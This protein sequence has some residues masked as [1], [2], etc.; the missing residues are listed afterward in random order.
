MRTLKTISPGQKGTKRLLAQ[1]GAS[2][3][4]V[5]YRYDRRQRRRCKTVELIVEERPWEPPTA[6][7]KADRLA[8][9]RVAWGEASVAARIKQAGGRW[10]PARRLWELPYS[11]AKALGLE[12]RIEG[13]EASN[14]SHRKNS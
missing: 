8:G 14:T 4:C 12:G 5:R 2:L 9:V 10:N 3:V 13:L 6:R 1:Y 11:R 7:P